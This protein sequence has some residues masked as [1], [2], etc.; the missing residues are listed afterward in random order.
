MQLLR[1]LDARLSLEQVAHFR[2]GA[3]H[4]PAHVA[5][6]QAHGELCPGGH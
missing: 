4:G 1:D 5:P 2:A 6:L 3:P